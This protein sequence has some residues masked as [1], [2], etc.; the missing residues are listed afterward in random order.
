MNRSPDQLAMFGGLATPPGFARARAIELRRA[1]A[2]R[3]ARLPGAQL[4]IDRLL[5]VPMPARLRDCRDAGPVHDVIEDLGG[6]C[7]ILRCRYNLAL[8]VR[9]NGSIKVEDGHRLGGT[10]QHS[11][12]PTAADYERMAD[13]V[14]E[15][16]DRLGTLCLWDLLPDRPMS[17]ADHETYMTNEAIGRLLGQSKESARKIVGDAEQAQQIEEARQARAAQRE[18]QASSKLVRIRPRPR[19]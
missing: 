6:I 18:R 7:P 14:V 10:L 3:R 16:A 15:L 12:E 8:W 13:R 2:P 5:L 9:E 4:H 19:Q 11:R 17:F 1:S